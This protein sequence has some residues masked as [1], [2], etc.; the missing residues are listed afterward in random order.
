M[1]NYKSVIVTVQAISHAYDL[2]LKKKYNWNE[3]KNDLKWS[4]L[5]FRFK[6]IAEYN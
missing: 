6:K 4:S 1:R 5:L 2:P 3:K